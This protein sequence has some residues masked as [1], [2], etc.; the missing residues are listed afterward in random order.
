MNNLFISL[1]LMFTFLYAPLNNNGDTYINKSTADY[2]L[3]S[4]ESDEF[5]TYWKN[6]FRKDSSGKIIDICNI[7]KESF[8]N[9][10]YGHYA[11]LSSGAKAEVNAHQDYEEGYT[12]KD[13]ISQ[14][15]SMYSTN[16]Q[17]VSVGSKLDQPTSII[18]VI[19]VAVFGVSTICIFFIF[20]QNKLIE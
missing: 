16:N 13:S 3:K 11:I 7:S 5:I 15:A 20:K 4:A 9:M 18:I 6:D 1:G 12:I 2:A 10:Y 17:N 19:S 8:L 14:L